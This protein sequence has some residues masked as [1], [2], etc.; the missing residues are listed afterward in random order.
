MS[1]RAD[2]ATVGSIDLGDLGAELRAL[3]RR[4]LHSALASFL[5]WCALFAAGFLYFLFEGIAPLGPPPWLAGMAG[6]LAGI[7]LMVGA[8]VG[9]VPWALA[10]QVELAAGE[11]ARL[12]S[13]IVRESALKLQARMGDGKVLDV[14]VVQ[15]QVAAVVRAGTERLGGEP[16]IVGPRLQ[17]WAPS[18]VGGALR[19]LIRHFVGK[20]AVQGQ[21]QVADLLALGERLATSAALFSL[22]RAVFFVL[23]GLLIAAGIWIGLPLLIAALTGLALAAV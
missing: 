21:V 2:V 23:A 20:V 18:L 3:A 13:R 22:R 14:A 12:A 8:V 11:A 15:E 17:A 6:L 7:W 16:G 19:W 4:R 5:L 1:E 9:G 10:V